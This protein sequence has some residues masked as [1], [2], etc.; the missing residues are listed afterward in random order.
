MGTYL[1][2]I[3]PMARSMLVV[4]FALSFAWE[5]TDTF[6]YSILNSTTGTLS[7]LVLSLNSM[8]IAG[9]QRSYI[10][11][12]NQ[13]AGAILA[14]LPLLL[15]YAVLQKQIIQGIERSGIVG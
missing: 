2:I 3:L 12:I 14:I 10:S 8:S 11:A 6:Y 1:R 7:Q 9:E 13:N 4:V 15:F 5:W